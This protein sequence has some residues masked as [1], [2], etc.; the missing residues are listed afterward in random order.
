MRADRLMRWPLAV[1][2]LALVAGACGAPDVVAVVD[3]KEIAATEIVALHPDGLSLA[4][5]EQ[6]AST[7]LVILHHLL[8][9]EAEEVFGIVPAGADVERAFAERTAGLEDVDDGLA[10]RGVTRSRVEL[11]AELDVLRDLL[12]REFVSRNGDADLDAAYRRFVSVN[13]IA[14]VRLLAPASREL[15]P[16]IEALVFAGASGE[17]I[18]AEMGDGVEP[19]ELGCVSPSQHPEGVASVAVDGEVGKAYQRTFSDGTMY[20]AIV[21][22]RDA[23]PMSEVM[24]EVLSIA[25]DTEGRDRFDEWAFEVLRLADVEVDPS[26]GTWEPTDE[27]GGVPTVVAP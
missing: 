1:A 14:C 8:L 21:T 5:E 25:A 15:E 12:Q 16:R 26:V 10:G 3:G 18:E 9:S 4:P 20:V 2:A 22:E 24:D 27:T 19:I 23:P 17:E 7:F 11:E 13:S 6:A